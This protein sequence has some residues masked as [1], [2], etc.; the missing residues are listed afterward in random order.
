ML[1]EFRKRLGD[2]I[3]A[4]INEMI[5]AY[6][7]PDDPDPGSGGEM[8]EGSKEGSENSGT[9]ILDATCAPQNISYPQDVNLMNEEREN[10]ESLIDRICYDY[11]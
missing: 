2:E 10:L 4:Q 11:S 5:I 1:V 3:L 7:M 9:V 8:S 6:I